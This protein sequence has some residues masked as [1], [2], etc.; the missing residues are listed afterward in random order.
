M[1]SGWAQLIG[2]HMM[3]WG[4]VKSRKLWFLGPEEKGLDVDE[5]ATKGPDVGRFTEKG[6]DVDE[7]GVKRPHVEATRLGYRYANTCRKGMGV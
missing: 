2:T 4:R 5:V 3:L 1:L 7:V 6:P